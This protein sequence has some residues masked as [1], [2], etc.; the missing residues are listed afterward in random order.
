M[1]HPIT[2]SDATFTSTVERAEGLTLVDFW[3]PWCAPCLF[4]A[5][6]LDRA[7]AEYVGRVRI[8]K[9]NVDENPATA[10]RFD[11]RSIP[12]LLLFRDGRLVDDL[13]GVVPKRDL[14]AFLAAH[15]DGRDTPAVAARRG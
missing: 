1:S 4:L 13:V 10:Q 5:P 7:A 9:L 8:A 15:L 12:R 2:I 14:D 11:I 3:A 6:L